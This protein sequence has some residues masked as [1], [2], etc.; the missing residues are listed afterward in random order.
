M[1]IMLLIFQ[2]RADHDL[3]L[4]KNWIEDVGHRWGSV[5]LKHRGLSKRTGIWSIPSGP[6][7]GVFLLYEHIG[8]AIVATHRITVHSWRGVDT[9]HKFRHLVS[10]E[11]SELLLRSRRGRLRT[12]GR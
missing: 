8:E 6:Q 2:I 5:Y 10:T 7:F 9:R 4:S 1:L 11:W 3:I 12:T